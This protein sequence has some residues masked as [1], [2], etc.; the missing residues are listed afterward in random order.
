[1]IR[2][3]AEFKKSSKEN[4]RLDPPTLLLS[5]NSMSEEARAVGG[6]AA[7]DVQQ[8]QV[9]PG[10]QEDVP[11][12][13]LENSGT[14]DISSDLLLGESSVFPESQA[15]KTTSNTGNE[16]TTSNTGNEAIDPFSKLQS[17]MEMNF[18]SIKS[19]TAT[20]SGQLGMLQNNVSNLNS[21]VQTLKSDFDGLNGRLTNVTAQA[22]ANKCGIANVNK[23]LKEMQAKQADTISERVAEAVAAEMGKVRADVP[24]DVATKFDKINKEIDRMKALQTVQQMKPGPR[25]QGLPDAARRP[26]SAEEESRQYWAIRRKIRCSPVDP[27]RDGAELLRNVHAFFKNVLAIPEGEV[28]DDA[29]MDVKKVPGRRRSQ[30]LQ[31]VVI[32][33]DSI[34]TRDCVASYAPNLADWRGRNSA[35]RASLRLEIPDYL[36][37]VFRVLER[38]AHQLKEKNPGYFKRSIKYDDVNLTLVL[39]FCSREGAEWRRVHYDDAVALTRGRMSSSRSSTSSYHSGSNGDPCAPGTSGMC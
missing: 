32:T 36:C 27:G 10:A 14:L 17:F 13:E 38:H 3:P 35:A 33:F 23:Q 28:P 19:D 6:E 31:E 39:D 34:Q 21:S 1:M 30:N 18:A 20:M 16:E 8:T 2:S 15:P 12:N 24:V 5:L 11:F 4:F 37:G 22:V 25:G 29:I 7:Q 9:L 26:S